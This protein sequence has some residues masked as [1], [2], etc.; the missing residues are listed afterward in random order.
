MHRRELVAYIIDIFE[1]FLDE[2][3]VRVPNPERDAE[4]PDNEANIYGEDFDVLM[5][6]IIETLKSDGIRVADDFNGGEDGNLSRLR[7]EFYRLIIENVGSRLSFGAITI[8][9]VIGEDS[10][11]ILTHKEWAESWFDFTEKAIQELREKYDITDVSI[12]DMYDRN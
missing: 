12:E 7:N 4:D 1:D 8:K 3:G 2:K 10:V 5:D 9:A 6:K 11:E